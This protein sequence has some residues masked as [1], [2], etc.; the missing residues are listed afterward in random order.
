MN[1][2]ITVDKDIE[3]RYKYRKSLR[4]LYTLEEAKLKYGWKLE[5][6]KETLFKYF[7]Q[8]LK[9]YL[10]SSTVDGGYIEPEDKINDFDW[11]QTK[12]LWRAHKKE[13]FKNNKRIKYSDFDINI[14]FINGEPA[15][16]SGGILTESGLKIDL[17]PYKGERGILLNPEIEDIVKELSVNAYE[18]EG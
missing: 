15:N 7:G 9:Y 11:W 16:Y 5:E 17:Y 4:E 3:S 1:E 12:F 13:R 18:L 2:V 8:A 14:S 10:V 6:V